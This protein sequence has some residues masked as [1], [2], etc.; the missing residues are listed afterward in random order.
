MLSLKSFKKL[1][2]DPQAAAAGQDHILVA[3][4]RFSR[5]IM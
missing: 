3:V 1:I 5:S 2:A 4:T